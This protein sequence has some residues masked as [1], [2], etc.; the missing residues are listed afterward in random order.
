MRAARRHTARRTPRAAASARS[1]SAASSR[2]ASAVQ[3]VP[4]VGRRFALR[5]PRLHGRARS[6]PRATA[7]SSTCV[8]AERERAG[9]RR[10]LLAGSGG[11]DALRGRLAVHRRRPTSRAARSA[12]TLCRN[13][14]DCPSQA[15]CLEYQTPALPTDGAR[16]VGHVHA[17]VEDRRHGLPARGRLS[18]GA[19]LRALRRA[20]Q[21]ARSAGAGGTEVARHG[22]TGAAECRSGECYDRDFH[23]SGGQNRAFCSGACAGEQRLRPRSALRR[24]WSSAT[25]ARRRPARRPGGRLLPHAVRAD[26]RDGLRD[27]RRLRRA[28]GRLGHL[29]RRAR[30]LLP[31]GGRARVGLHGATRLPARRRSAARA[32]ASPGG[33]CQTFGCDRGR[34]VGRGR[35][36]GHEQRLRAARRSR[37]ADLGLLRE[38]HAGRRAPAAA[39]RAGYAC[40]SLDAERAAQR[41]PGGQRDVTAMRDLDRGAG[42]GRGRMER[43]RRAP[44]RR[45]R[46]SRR[47]AGVRRRAARRDASPPPAAPAPAAGAGARAAGRR[48]RARRRVARRARCPPPTRP[49]RR[50]I[51]TRSSVTSASRRAASIPGRAARAARRARLSDGRRR[52]GRLRGDDGRGRGALLVDAQPGARTPALAFGVGRRAR[53]RRAASTR[54]SASARSSG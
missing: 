45:R 13:D 46:P 24:G 16:M 4:A 48:Q 26:R 36:P 37:R 12:R 6:W 11:G 18:G 39:P 35:L 51:T 53:R 28:P 14:A 50:P 5:R 20:H 41:L 1:T 21:P 10:R 17:G 38:V 22:C 8:D 47:R 52:H 34:D 29:R 30:P 23:V 49:R 7:S 27:R 32:R 40:E 43:V 44:R 15:R 3:P 42:C 2:S 33:Y 54:T 9:V 31:Q 25:T 19:G